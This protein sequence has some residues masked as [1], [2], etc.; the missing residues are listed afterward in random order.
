MGG[1]A[2]LEA[3]RKSRPNVTR[4]GDE[5]DRQVGEVAD[6]R[7]ITRSRLIREAVEA[8][9]ATEAEERRAAS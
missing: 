3:S 9:L 4:F 2:P 5:L 7:R 6:R 8:Y 1:R